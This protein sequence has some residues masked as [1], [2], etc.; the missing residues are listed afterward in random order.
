[1]PYIS[2]TYGL[3]SIRFHPR[4]HPKLLNCPWFSLEYCIEYQV[5][6]GAVLGY[7]YAATTRRYVVM[8]DAEDADFGKLLIDLVRKLHINGLKIAPVGFRVRNNLPDIARWLR[9]LGLPATMPVDFET[10]NN[11]ESLARLNHVGIK[12]SWGE[13]SRASQEWHEVALLAA[14]TELWRCVTLSYG[15]ELAP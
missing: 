10:A 14:I 11:V 12:L 8:T 2:I 3:E 1:M 13:L 5:L 9:I 6:R 4:F 15:F 7:Y